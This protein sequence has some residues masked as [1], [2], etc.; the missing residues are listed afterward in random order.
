[1]LSATQQPD[2]FLVLLSRAVHCLLT[3]HSD[4][5]ATVRMAAEEALQ[6]IIH[7]IQSAQY[8]GHLWL[9]FFRAIQVLKPPR[10]RAVALRHFAHCVAWV[11]PWRSRTIAAGVVQLTRSALEQA[12][13]PAQANTTSFMRAALPEV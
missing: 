3:T 4:S 8:Q 5:D 13:L 7:G 11:S 9:M 1:L 12:L 10:S 2:I 6:A